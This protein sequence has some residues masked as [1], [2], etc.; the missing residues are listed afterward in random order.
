MRRTIALYLGLL[1]AGVA[2]VASLPRAWPAIVARI[3][4][5][6]A[7]SLAA[8]RKRLK[9]EISVWKA[10]YA[11]ASTK[12]TVRTQ[13]V[14]VHAESIITLAPT[15]L[16]NLN[17]PQLVTQFVNLSVGAART[18]TA[19]ASDCATLRTTVDSLLVKQDTL[20]A[21]LEKVRRQWW[22][23]FGANVCYVPGRQSSVAGALCYR[24]WP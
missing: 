8:E 22:D 12:V 13:T 14:Y 6:F 4:R 18:C 17:N 20:T 7:D 2:V 21:N 15:V 24:V 5:P 11:E 9:D 16:Q 10:R 23:R 1:I 3:Q 19:L